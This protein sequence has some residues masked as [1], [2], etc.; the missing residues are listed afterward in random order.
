MSIPRQA[1]ADDALAAVHARMRGNAHR[2]AALHVPGLGDP[3][4]RLRWREADGEHFV[5]AEDIRRGRL[6][7]YT[8]FN[9]LVELHRQADR[10]VRSPH[11][12]YHPDYQRRGLATAIYRWALGRGICLMSGARQSPGA[13]AL[14]LRLSRQCE[15]GFVDLRHRRLRYL[16][17][18]VTDAAL[19]ELSTRMFLLGEGWTLARFRGE[20]RMA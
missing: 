20:T 3:D 12:L 14:W 1:R 2:L 17:P 16:G 15:A 7:G 10:H 13:H 11:S 19:A 9:R 18:A 5:Y 4:L 6:A 8:V